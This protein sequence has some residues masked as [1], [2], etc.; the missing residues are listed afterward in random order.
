MKYLT[1][2]FLICLFSFY[3]PNLAYSFPLVNL[4]NKIEV[5]SNLNIEVNKQQRA[6]RLVVPELVKSQKNTPLVF[7]FHGL[8]DSKDL[9]PL[10]S[11]LDQ[12]AK[13]YG[14]ILVYLNGVDKRWPLLPLKAGDDLA[15]FDAIYQK[16]TTEYSIDINRVYLTGMSNGAYFINIVAQE[17]SEKIAAIAP[18]S[19]SLGALAYR[20][21]KAK[22]K[23]AVIVIHGDADNI[24]SVREGRK[25]QEAYKSA[26]HTVEYIEVA[27]LGHMW[28]NKIDVNDKI[29]QF[30]LAHPKNK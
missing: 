9:M 24:L 12:A 29:W 27:G 30:F 19:G 2:L 17:R 28:A 6:Y 5:F 7:A 13:K 20:G 8:G 3:S 11:H 1:Y 21:L 10:Y 26:G 4:D 25:M 15:F 14:F 16:L 23:Y 18:H 22:N